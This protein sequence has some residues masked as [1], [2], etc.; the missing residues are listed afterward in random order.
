MTMSFN[1]LRLKLSTQNGRKKKRNANLYFFVVVVIVVVSTGCVSISLYWHK[2]YTQE[3][4]LVNLTVI[5][6]SQIF[7]VYKL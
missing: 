6:I 3:V 2:I 1:T 4:T 7:K 5:Y